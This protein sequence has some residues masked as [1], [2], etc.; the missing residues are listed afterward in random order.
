[1]IEEHPFNYF[2]TEETNKLII[3]S[4]PCFNGADYG[5]W[6]YSGS[7]KNDFWKL[8]SE[9]FSHPISTLEEKKELCIQNK[10][11]IADIALKIRRKKDNCSDSNLEILE[12]NNSVIELCLKNGIDRIFFTSK[13]VEKHFKNQFPSIT[14]KSTVL[15]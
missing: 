14:I 3:G 2:K 1:M 11:G 5:D 4:F 10:I 12:Y 7:G 15:L 6:F 8:L 9:V 13:F